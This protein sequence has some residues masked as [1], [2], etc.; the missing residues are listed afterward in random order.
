MSEAGVFRST[1]HTS[2]SVMAFNEGTRSQGIKLLTQIMATNPDA[3]TLMQKE[4]KANE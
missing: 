4:A 1:F 3:F 2:G